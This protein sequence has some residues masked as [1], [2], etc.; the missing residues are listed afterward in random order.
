M[1]GEV[2]FIPGSPFTLQ[3][4]W[5]ITHSCALAKFTAVL[6]IL[7]T[8]WLRARYGVKSSLP[9]L[10]RPTEEPSSRIPFVRE[11][12]IIARLADAS[13]PD[14]APSLFPPHQAVRMDKFIR[15]SDTLTQHGRS[16]LLAAL[17]HDPDTTQLIVLPRSLQNWFFVPFLLRLV[18]SYMKSKYPLE[19]TRDQAREALLSLRSALESSGT[20]YICAGHFTYADI[21]MCA[22]MYFAVE[23]SPRSPKA[24]LFADTE[25]SSEFSDLVTWRKAMFAKH[26][27]AISE[28][29]AYNAKSS[30]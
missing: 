3:V 18:Y 30:G 7:T 6:P 5:A 12:S 16:L 29:N 9:I 14:G 19:P 28:R 11:S 25:F 26:L 10:F 22:S 21:C 4:F 8:I 1:L 17:L 15:A 23:W 13:R 24:K 2:W 27:P 20:S